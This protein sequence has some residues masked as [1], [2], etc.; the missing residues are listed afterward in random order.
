MDFIKPVEYWDGLKTKEQLSKEFEYNGLKFFLDYQ[1]KDGELEK[2][3][4]D[5]EFKNLAEQLKKG[6][7][8]LIKTLNEIEKQFPFEKKLYTNKAEA[9]LR[10]ILTSGSTR[11]ICIAVYT[12]LLLIALEN[13]YIEHIE[14]GFTIP[15][16]RAAKRAYKRY[17]KMQEEAA[18]RRKE[19]EKTDEYRTQKIELK[20]GIRKSIEYPE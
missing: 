17:L 13:D 14:K 19:F 5:E 15:E 12:K 1:Q 3:F 11:P 8:K 9:I 4:K 7:A 18:Q 20:L 6:S 10:N 2:F 16:I